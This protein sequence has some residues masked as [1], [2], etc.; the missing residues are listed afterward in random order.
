MNNPDIDLGLAIC[1]IKNR[2]KQLTLEEISAYC[3]CSRNRIHQ[4]EQKALAKVRRLLRL[5]GISRDLAEA[6]RGL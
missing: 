6:L 3:G 2:G 5:Q 1:P 4:I